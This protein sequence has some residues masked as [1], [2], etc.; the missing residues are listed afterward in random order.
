MSGA[1][2]DSLAA[3]RQKG[4]PFLGSG[5]RFFVCQRRVLS[6]RRMKAVLTADNRLLVICQL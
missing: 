6:W 3:L 2:K 4:T 1:G 5:A